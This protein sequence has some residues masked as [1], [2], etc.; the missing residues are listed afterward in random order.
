M[1]PAE[2]RFR[3]FQLYMDAKRNREHLLPKG[4]DEDQFSSKPVEYLKKYGFKVAKKYSEVY[5]I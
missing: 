1:L 3:G 5:S 2:K 4:V